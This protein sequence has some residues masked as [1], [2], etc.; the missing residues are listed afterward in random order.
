MSIAPW[1]PVTCCHKVTGL[2]HSG[3]QDI[4]TGKLELPIP[5]AAEA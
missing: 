4:P 3:H 2:P 1:P 5:L